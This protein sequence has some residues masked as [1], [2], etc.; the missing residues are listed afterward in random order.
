MVFGAWLKVLALAPDGFWLAFLG[1]ALV[2][3][4][5]VFVLGVPAQLAA[6]WFGPSQVSTACALGV[7]GNE[8][9]VAL[10]FL[11]PPAVVK[12][13]DKL[14]DIGQDLNTLCYGYAIGPT[15]VLVLLLLFFQKEPPLPPSPAQ[16]T[17]RCQVPT[18]DKSVHRLTY[19]QTLKSLL[20]NRNFVLLL[21]SYGINAGVFYAVSTLLNQIVLSHF[22]GAEEDAGRIGLTIV[23]AGVLGS[24]MG[25]VML[26]K[27]HW[28]K[29]SALLVYLMSLAGMLAFT[30]TLTLGYIWVTYVIGM[31][32]GFFMI[33]YLGIGFE[34]AAELTYPIPE[35]ISSGVL[36]VSSEIFGI[37]F[38]VGG[39]E[40][41]DSY[42][43]MSANLTLLGLLVVGLV[44]T[45]QINGT[46]LRRQ[47][48]TARLEN[49]TTC[50]NTSALKPSMMHTSSLSLTSHSI[51]P[52]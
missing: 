34:F 29:Q 8:V 20:T 46:D 16:A 10:G 4:A 9:G 44:M 13:H 22:A 6:V 43:D 51:F 12:N 39:G 50:N 26:D 33:G 24:L 35:G 7:I 38:T 49:Q 11:I 42:G 25:G 48:V 15:A 18:S 30:F 23:L 41:L 2:G 40:L 1:Q 37:A 5:Q 28:F 36:M 21:I 45:T 27:T 31:L 52:S 19:L 14:D 17:V 47:A 32:L 3:S